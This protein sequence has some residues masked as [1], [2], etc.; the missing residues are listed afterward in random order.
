MIAILA[1]SPASLINAYVCVYYYDEARSLSS[2][3]VLTV[4]Q[5]DDLDVMLILQ[6]EL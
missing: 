1:A 5:V 3:S 4:A 2:V 6:G